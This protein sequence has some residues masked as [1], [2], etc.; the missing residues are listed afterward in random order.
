MDLL[1]EILLDASRENIPFCVLIELTRRCNL[2]CMHCYALRDPSRGELPTARLREVL[3]ELREM[4]TL[5]LTFTG[6]EPMVREDFLEILFYAS[7]KGFSI[8][9]ST[10]GVLVDKRIAKTLSGLKIFYVGL[11]LYGATPQTH[12]F[13][14]GSK[15][16]FER[17]LQAIRLLKGEGLHLVL[18]FIMMKPNQVEYRGMLRLA[19]AMELPYRI[20]TLI[21]PR[22][23][24][25]YDTRWLAVDED[26]LSEI[27]KDHFEDSAPTCK[28]PPE[29]LGDFTCFMGKTLC[30]INAYG[31]LYPCVQLPIPA[32]NLL[33][34]SFREIWEGSA[35][36]E[37]I[38]NY[39]QEERLQICARCELRP[40]CH[41]CPG[42]VYLET[43]DLYASCSRSCVEAKVWKG[44]VEKRS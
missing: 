30:S 44:L 9:L 33:E 40:Y 7:Q 3:D 18:K 43:G 42:S 24:L 25:S 37:E 12:D 32:G 26:L 29:D 10:N 5:Y 17:T 23:D 22:D 13:I 34:S 31:D 16:S 2:Q 27:F 4:G 15:G 20:D 19:E 36:L 1:R 21:T 14:T 38:R 39:P 11:S 28:T 41:R 6:G 35:L 8:Q